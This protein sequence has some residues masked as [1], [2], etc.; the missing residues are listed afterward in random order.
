VRFFC[1]VVG[2]VMDDGPGAENVKKLAEDYRDQL[3]P[4]VQRLAPVAFGGQGG[5]T[6]DDTGISVKRIRRSPRVIVRRK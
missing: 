2:A 3:Y 1:A 4:I 6:V 5:L